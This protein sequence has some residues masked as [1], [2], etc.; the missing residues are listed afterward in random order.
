MF[1][2]DPFMRLHSVVHGR[3]SALALL[4]FVPLVSGCESL[5]PG[6]LLE[7]SGEWLQRSG[8]ILQDF[9]KESAASEENP[10]LK[11]LFAQPYIDPLTRYLEKN[12]TNAAQQADWQSVQAERDRRCSVVAKRFEQIAVSESSVDRF[13][14]GYAYSCPT[15]VA[16]YAARLSALQAQALA[17]ATNANHADSADSANK[18]EK[19]AAT[20]TATLGELPKSSA[21]AKP[22][23]SEMT[24]DASKTQQAGSQASEC[25]LLTSIKNYREALKACEPPAE[26]GDARAQ[27]SMAHIYYLFKQ[28]NQAFRWASLAGKNSAESSFLLAQMHER[29]QGTRTD[30]PSALRWYEAAE[31]LG[32]P[33]ARAEWLRLN[34]QAR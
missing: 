27:T 14:R 19:T 17:N 16:A 5:R 10:S 23:Q 21:S 9:G 30:R 15:E 20:Q 13:R 4:L 24:L 22:L 6:A 26:Q 3:R 7:Q 32:H 33:Q 18:A 1:K 34:G 25:Y 2:K 12:R 29:G 8:E 28:Y 11:T 31:K